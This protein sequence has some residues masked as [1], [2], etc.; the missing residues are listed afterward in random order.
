M[1]KIR[2]NT[3]RKIYNDGGVVII[4]PCKCHPGAA[5]LMGFEIQ[6]DSSNGRDFD[7]VIYEFEYYNC[8]PEHGKYTAFYLMED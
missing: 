3:A 2:K 4:L 7:S 1:K 6:I 8:N 5:W